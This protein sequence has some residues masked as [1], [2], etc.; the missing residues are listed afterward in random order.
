MY[1]S[2]CNTVCYI[3]NEIK[4]FLTVLCVSLVRG[5]TDVNECFASVRRI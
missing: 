1:D 5:Y 2:M 4:S 3:G